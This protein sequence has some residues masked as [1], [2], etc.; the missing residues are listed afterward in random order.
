MQN[1]VM[2]QIY[3]SLLICKSKLIETDPQQSL[4]LPLFGEQRTTKNNTPALCEWAIG[5][6]MID[7]LSTQGNFIPNDPVIKNARRQPSLFQITSLKNR[8]KP[9]FS[10]LYKSAVKRQLCE[11]CPFNIY[12]IV[13]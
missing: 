12:G 2:K 1:P 6:R 8:L 10:G 9:V 7:L 4:F 5:T 11:T 13:I 3:I